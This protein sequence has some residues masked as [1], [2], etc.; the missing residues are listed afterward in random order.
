MSHEN[1]IRQFLVTN[2]APDMDPSE[3][4]AD[5]DLLEGGVIDSLG[6]LTLIS[7]V[8]DHFGIS[9]EDEDLSPAKFS[10]VDSIRTYVDSQVPASAGSGS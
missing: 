5:Y 7:W 3:I 10:S 9:V 1:T 6:L 8:E 4:E 2:F